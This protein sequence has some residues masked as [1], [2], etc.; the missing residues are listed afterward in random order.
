MVLIKAE[1]SVCKMRK[2][3][4]APYEYRKETSVGLTGKF[5]VTRLGNC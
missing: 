3:R 4:G 5:E 2:E 1:K